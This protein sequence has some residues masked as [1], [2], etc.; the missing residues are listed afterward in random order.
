MVGDRKTTSFATEAGDY[1]RRA[2]FRRMAAGSHTRPRSPA[3]GRSTCAPSPAP[4]GS[5]RSRRTVAALR[6]GGATGREL[7]YL[8]ADNKIMAVPVRLDPTFQAGSPAALF[9]VRPNSLYDVS[10]DG[11]RFLVNSASAEEALAAYDA[12]DRLDGAPQEI[13]DA[14]DRHARGSSPNGRGP[15]T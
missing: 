11:E 7:F 2:A 6:G 14:P 9:S 5:G 12:V 15:R 10:A 3:R 4:E 13:G 8:S 1:R